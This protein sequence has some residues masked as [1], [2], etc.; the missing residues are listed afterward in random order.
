MLSTHLTSI[1]A[2]QHIAELHRAAAHHRLAHANREARRPDTDAT[3][4]I[5]VFMGD[6]NRIERCGIDATS[7]NSGNRIVEPEAAVDQ[8]ARLRGGD[9]KTVALAATSQ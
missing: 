3:H 6:D 5:V 8:D 9:E 4:V 7:F 2:Q 1:I